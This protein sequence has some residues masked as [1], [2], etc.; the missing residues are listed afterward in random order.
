MKNKFKIH[1][2]LLF[3]LLLPLLNS[4]K[5]DLDSNLATPV[6][7]PDRGKS[8]N[9]LIPYRF[10]WEHTDYM[11]APAGT[12]ILVPWASGANRSFP[13]IYA[14]D[15]KVA[16]GWELVYNT[17]SPTST[18]QPLYF[19]LY[20]RYR[21]LLRGYFY[22][23]PG[24]SIPSSYITHALVQDASSNTAPLL[25]YS[26]TEVSN[27]NINTPV[28]STV[29]QYKTSATGTW[30]A[31]EFEMAYD[32]AI[33]AKTTQ[34]TWL[35]N[36]VNTSSIALTGSSQGTIQGT[37]SQ[38][39]PPSNLL[40]ATIPGIL[41]F[42]YANLI[43]SWKL[44]APVTSALKTALSSGLGGTVKNVLNGMFGGAS[45]TT[46]YANLT[47][48]AQYTLSGSITDTYQ[49]QNPNLNIPGSKGQNTGTGYSPLYTSPLGV[50]SLSAAPKVDISIPVY[51]GEDVT[52]VYTGDQTIKFDPNSYQ[53][54]FNPAVINSSST[55]A[56]IQNLKQQIISFKNYYS[57]T[58][59]YAN[60]PHSDPDT[61]IPS[62]ATTEQIDNTTVIVDNIPGDYIIP[63]KRH[64]TVFGGGA[65]AYAS[66]DD[67]FTTNS[68]MPSTVLRVS[69]DV[70]PNNGTPKTTIVKSFNILVRAINYVE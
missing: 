38:S 67:I 20:N 2:Y 43:D 25:S 49:L 39:V 26:A 31:A 62:T 65:P 3:L 11:P 9:T 16:D 60:P 51:Y 29:Q 56:T 53:I 42:P 66:P 59:V 48:S 47:T 23:T 13:T 6:K 5:K 33:G 17:F 28:S 55:G 4:C 58:R 45:Q 68:S 36:S 64:V 40:G 12:N 52:I 22:L 24:S 35:V 54:Q 50:F 18:A 44:A 69:F 61:P 8:V 46:Q 41:T 1:Y 57:L 7:T 21:G 15:I 37:I 27:L 70:V 63:F 30:Y 34:M 14:T 10:D 19:I 32:P